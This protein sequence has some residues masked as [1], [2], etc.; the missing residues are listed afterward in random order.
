MSKAKFFRLVLLAS[1]VVFALGGCAGGASWWPILV[2][3]TVLGNVFNQQQA[4]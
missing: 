4:A 2:G 1:G 3:A